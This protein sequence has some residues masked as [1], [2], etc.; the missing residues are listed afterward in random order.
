MPSIHE[1]SP[2]LHWDQLKMWTFRLNLIPFNL[3]MMTPPCFEV[4]GG[5]DDQFS[6]DNNDVDNLMRIRLARRGLS[7]NRYWA[8]ST[9][10]SCHVVCNF[11]LSRKRRFAGIPQSM[12]VFGI[13]AQGPVAVLL[14][15]NFESKARSTRADSNLLP[16]ARSIR[17]TFGQSFVA[18][19][20]DL[21][22]L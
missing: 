3:N 15:S 14:G 4:V 9:R 1:R 20:T 22:G 13:R 11:E 17:P 19:R 21:G 5:V 2:R 8:E 6:G 16:L 18:R 12:P 7:Y 10:G